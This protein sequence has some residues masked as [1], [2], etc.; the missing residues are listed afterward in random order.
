MIWL[1][2]LIDHC[3][4]YRDIF[5][6]ESPEVKSFIEGLPSKIL[7][8]T[9]VSM[10]DMTAGLDEFS[11]TNHPNAPSGTDEVRVGTGDDEEVYGHLS[12]VVLECDTRSG[13]VDIKDG[14][15]KDI[16]N[17]V[18]D[19][20]KG[21]SKSEL[22]EDGHVVDE[23]HKSG[24]NGPRVDLGHDKDLMSEID[25][26]DVIMEGGF[27]CLFPFGFPFKDSSERCGSQEI[28]HM[29]LQADNRFADNTEFIFYWFNN[30]GRLESCKGVHI[31]WR[32]GSSLLNH[33]TPAVL[34]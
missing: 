4:S 20:L 2:F 28:E 33:A 6:D 1:R 11:K 14:S 23:D 13:G 21:L 10:E 22:D 34:E 26:L 12:H 18:H 7:N 16:L 29:L 19:L 8:D 24:I 17:K 25:H 5:L 31:T 32:T 3:P 27:P 15:E 30:R 9:H